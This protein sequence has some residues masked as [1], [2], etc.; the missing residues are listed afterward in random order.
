MLDDKKLIDLL[1]D[2]GDQIS[3]YRYTA[4]TVARGIDP[5]RILESRKEILDRDLAKLIDYI[6]ESY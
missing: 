4:G 1:S 5:I 6:K 3:G 2:I